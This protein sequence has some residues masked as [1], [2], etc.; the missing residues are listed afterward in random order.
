MREGPVGEVAPSSLLCNARLELIRSL[1]VHS[2]LL[3]SAFE[4]VVLSIGY[5][6]KIFFFYRAV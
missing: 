5:P 1:S 2:F 3:P 4:T 6:E